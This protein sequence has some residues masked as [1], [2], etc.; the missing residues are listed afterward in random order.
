MRVHDSQAYRKMDV[1]RE[2][3]SR[4][5]EL[6]EIS[7]LARPVPGQHQAAPFSPS[8]TDLIR[9]FVNLLMTIVVVFRNMLGCFF[10]GGGGGCLVV[11]I[12]CCLLTVAVVTE[13]LSLS[14]S[15]SPSLSLSPSIS[16]PLLSFS[17]P[18]PFSMVFVE[19]GA[20]TYC[21]RM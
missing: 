21:F 14:L 3:I 16:P 13:L 12:A 5:L 2:R 17:L 11:W 7:G 4:I 19:K 8:L 1:T 18:L 6:R 15:P 20:D 10:T 9:L